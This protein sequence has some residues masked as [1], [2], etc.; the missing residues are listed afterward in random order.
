[1]K[2]II[3]KEMEKQFTGSFYTKIF[4]LLGV[5]LILFSLFNIFQINSAYKLIEKKVSE[6]KEAARPADLE[7]LVIT[8]GSCTT[9]FDINNVVNTVKSSKVNVV[10]ERTIDYSSEEAKSIIQKYDLEKLPT[11]LITGEL[12]KA[13][14]RDFEEKDDALVFT[15]LTPPYVDAKS[16]KVLGEVSVTLLKDSSCNNCSDLTTLLGSIKQIGVKILGEKI[17][18]KDSKE[19]QDLI[20]KYKIKKLPTLI[21]S[22]DIELYDTDFVKGWSQI[23]TISSDGSYIL[24]NINP[25]YLDLTTNDIKGLVSMT[26]LTDKSCADCYDPDQFHKLILQRMGVFINKEKKI[27]ISEPDGKAL[28][29]KYNITKIPTILLNGDVEEYPVLIQAW[30]PVGSKEDDGVYVFRIVEVAG[31]PY[32]DLNTNKV[33]R[34]EQSAKE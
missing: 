28:I 12:K 7:L 8:A 16:G 15:K 13:S 5:A 22:K 10:K 29:K 1:M 3:K 20:A 32:L 19:G 30:A 6:A 21:F 17:I 18:E 26:V 24:K 27:D 31:Q 4:T 2:N 33:V 9:C 23:G 11:V 25:P 34:P 14:I